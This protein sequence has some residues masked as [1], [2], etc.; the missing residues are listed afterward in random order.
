MPTSAEPRFPARFDQ[1]TWDASSARSTPA[2][3]TAA[4]AARREYERDDAP[5]SHL[6]PCEPEGRDGNNLENCVKAYVPQPNGPFGMVFEIVKID[7]RLRLEFLAFGVR[8][9]PK[10]SHAPNA[11][12]L[13]GQRVAE[14]TARDLR[15]EEPEAP[16]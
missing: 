14:I 12:D 9:H 3:R 11:Y 4:Q 1:D 6:K 7:G 8:H 15:G 2:G 16:G 13:A 10:R 5:V